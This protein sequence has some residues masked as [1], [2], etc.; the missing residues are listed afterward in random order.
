[1]RELFASGF[2]CGSIWTLSLDSPRSLAYYQL[3]A[4][5]M[6]YV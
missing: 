2:V 1:M 3:W 4:F 6:S 5:L